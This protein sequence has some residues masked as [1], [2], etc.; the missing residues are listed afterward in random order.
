[1]PARLLDV[2]CLVD[3][4]RLLEA[5][6]HPCRQVISVDPDSILFLNHEGRPRTAWLHVDENGNAQIRRVML[7][8]VAEPPAGL[9]VEPT[10]PPGH[11]L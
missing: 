3:A 6:R 10:E 8:F 4:R 9:H 11:L 7:G 2:D 5:A 1:M